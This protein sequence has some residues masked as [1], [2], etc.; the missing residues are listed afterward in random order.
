MKKTTKEPNGTSFHDTVITCTVQTLKDILGEE[1]YGN[2][3]G[4]DKVNYEWV[5][6][7]EKGDVFTV[8]DWK[9]YRRLNDTDSI[10]WHIGGFSRRVTEQAKEE[11]IEAIYKGK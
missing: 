7:T 5:L 8:Y 4:E 10:E 9:E 1:T 2:N 11:L 3:D 6:E